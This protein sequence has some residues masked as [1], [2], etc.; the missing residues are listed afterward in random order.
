MA[1]HGRDI[2][3]GDSSARGGRVTARRDRDVASGS[4][5]NGTTTYADVD[6]HAHDGSDAAR[7][8]RTITNGGGAAR[9]IVHIDGGECGRGILGD[10]GD[11]AD[12]R[13]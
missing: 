12:V 8:D 11:G 1:R 4:G 2:I 10:S 3:G 6:G 5:T 7:C 13:V 9:V